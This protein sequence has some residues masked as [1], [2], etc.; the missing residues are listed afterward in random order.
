M[1]LAYLLFNL[2]WHDVNFYSIHRAHLYPYISIAQ[3]P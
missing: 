1:V 2:G 3:D